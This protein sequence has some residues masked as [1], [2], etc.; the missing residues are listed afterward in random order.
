MYLALKKK[1]STDPARLKES[2]TE[3]STVTDSKLP[4]SANF[5]MSCLSGCAPLAVNFKNQSVNAD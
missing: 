2:G 4:A 3:T 5:D 1:L